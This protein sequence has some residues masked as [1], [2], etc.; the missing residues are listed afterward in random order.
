MLLGVRKS[1]I[2]LIQSESHQDSNPKMG[3]RRKSLTYDLSAAHIASSVIAVASFDF[4]PV[5]ESDRW[6][7]VGARSPVI[8]ATARLMAS[9]KW[10]FD[11]IFIDIFC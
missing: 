1:A 9:S 5:V 8:N 10:F 11:Q 6:P 7:W 3:F 2:A 4:F